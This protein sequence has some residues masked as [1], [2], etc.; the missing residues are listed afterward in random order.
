MTRLPN[1]EPNVSPGD[2]VVPVRGGVFAQ[3]DNALS[4]RVL[5]VR[6]YDCPIEGPEWMADT[7]AGSY[8][9]FTLAIREGGE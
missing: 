5:G 8:F 7:T 1:Y 3:A 6:V 4:A 2:T 9:T